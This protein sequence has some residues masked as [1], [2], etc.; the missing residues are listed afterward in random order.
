[1]SHET[2]PY[3]AMLGVD[4]GSWTPG[5]GCCLHLCA[6]EQ[7]EEEIQP[8]PQS[9]SLFTPLPGE[10]RVLF[11]YFV[12]AGCYSAPFFYLA[13]NHLCSALFLTDDRSQGLPLESDLGV[14]SSSAAWHLAS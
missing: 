12:Q 6:E 14:D 7:V 1:M 5:A 4:L 9:P 8:M 10:K 2:F 3:T 13:Q 11:N